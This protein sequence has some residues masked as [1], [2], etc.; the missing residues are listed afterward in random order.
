MLCRAMNIGRPRPMEKTMSNYKFTHTDIEHHQDYKVQVE[1]AGTLSL[2]DL[3]ET[4]ESFARACGYM[5]KGSLE[6]V[7]DDE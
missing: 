7:E 2:T 4:F 1:V 6:F 5:P 3:L